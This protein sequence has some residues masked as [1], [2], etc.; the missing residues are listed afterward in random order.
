MNE[1]ASYEKIRLDNFNSESVSIVKE[2]YVLV[3]GIETRL[4]MPERNAFLNTEAD[5]ERLR[6]YLGENN[7][8]YLTI[9]MLWENNTEIQEITSFNTSSN[10]GT[11]ASLQ[12][13]ITDLELAIAEIYES[14]S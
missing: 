5:K 2:T 11:L 9:L 6:N 12:E 1:L 13:S 14:I 10:N 4:G 3:D 8:Y 7:I